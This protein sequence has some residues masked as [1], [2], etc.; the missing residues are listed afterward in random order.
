MVDR[1]RPTSTS[2][3]RRSSASR[4][5]ATRS[6]GEITQ[7]LEDAFVT[8]FDREDIHELTVRLD[9]VVDGIQAI[10]ETFVI[11]DIDAADRRGARA[12]PHPRRPGG[13]AA[14]GAAQARRPQGPRHRTSSAVHD[15]EHEA[16]A[17]SRAAVGAAV[18]RGDRPAR[19][20]Q[21]A[22]PLPR[23]RERD[24][25][26][27]GRRRGHR[28]DVP[29]GDLS[30]RPPRQSSGPSSR[31]GQA[32]DAVAASPAPASAARRRPAAAS[33]LGP[34]RRSVAATAV[35]RPRGRTTTASAR[36][37]RTGAS[38]RRM[39]STSARERSSAG[40][41]P[42]G[43]S[44]LRRGRSARTRGEELLGRRGGAAERP[45]RRRARRDAV[46]RRALRGVGRRSQPSAVGQRCV[47]RRRVAAAFAD[48]RR[49]RGSGGD[50]RSDGRGAG[51]RSA[52]SPVASAGR[53]VARSARRHAPQVGRRNT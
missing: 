21:V 16:D 19:G 17:L 5:A 42:L 2:A 8:P 4:S 13:R 44:A 41:A 10:A 36:R 26:R 48:R 7:R 30:R 11:Y 27:R 15:L 12:R 22:R 28:A 38:W 18:P 29:Q 51:R 6:T 32:R 50:R 3:S 34:M 35:E 53:R 14:R 40:P 43:G 33:R 45:D 52:G 1:V 49:R 31:S 9:D 47:D 24:R 25:C 39:S 23:A 37:L 46:R 20:H